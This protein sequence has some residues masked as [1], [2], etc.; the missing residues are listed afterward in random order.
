[1]VE[2]QIEKNIEQIEKMAE[3]MGQ[4]AQAQNA[5]SAAQADSQQSN[6]GTVIKTENLSEPV[7]NVERLTEMEED[8]HKFG[9]F[10][11]DQ[12]ENAVHYD[13]YAAKY[14]GMQVNSGFND[15]YEIVKTTVEHLA[16]PGQPLANPEARLLDIGCGTGLLGIELQK[17]G[18]KNIYGIDGSAQMLAIAD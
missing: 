16:Q 4:R 9:V 18:Y 10:S 3:E 7:S 17:A 14:D 11:F 8:V 15:P 5:T 2:A 1:M 12:R 6:D 13:Q